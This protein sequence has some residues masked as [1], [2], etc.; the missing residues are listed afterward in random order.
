[1]ITKEQIASPGQSFTGLMDKELVPTYRIPGI[2]KRNAIMGQRLSRTF[3]EFCLDGNDEAFKCG[4][5]IGKVRQGYRNEKWAQNPDDSGRTT[6]SIDL[7]SQSGKLESYSIYR[8]L[9]SVIGDYRFPIYV[10][11]TALVYDGYRSLEYFKKQKIY[12]AEVRVALRFWQSE[13]MSEKM[14][15]QIAK[16]PDGRVCKVKKIKLSD[17]PLTQGFG[18]SDDDGKVGNRLRRLSDVF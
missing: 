2:N 14:N 1:M 6:D 5:V 16:L 7:L 18:T 8:G 17:N 15:N 10:P 3:A 4:A 13:Q 11:D 9:S 12:E